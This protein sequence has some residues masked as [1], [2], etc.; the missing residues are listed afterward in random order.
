MWPNVGPLK[1]S[2]EYQELNVE[3]CECNCYKSHYWHIEGLLSLFRDG[4]KEAPDVQHLA[5]A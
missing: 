2:T 5:A 3:A 1:D 4:I